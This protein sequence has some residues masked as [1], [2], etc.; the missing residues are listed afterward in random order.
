MPFGVRE[1]SNLTGQIQSILDGYPL[2]DAILREFLQN[3]DDAKA[4]KQIFVLDG[5]SHPKKYIADPILEECQGPALLAINDT[6]FHRDDWKALGTIHGSNKATDETKTGKY[7]LGFRACYHLT[8]NPHVLSG[9]QLR[10]FDPHED[11]QHPLDG[12]FFINTIEEAEKFVDHITAFQAAEVIPHKAYDGTA[13]RLPLRNDCQAK[14]SK[15]RSTAFS[16]DYIRSLFTNFVDRELAIVLLFLKHIRSVE[17]REIEANGTVKVIGRVEISGAEGSLRSD[18]SVGQRSFRCQTIF[19]GL[20]GKPQTRHWRIIHHLIGRSEACGILSPRLEYSPDE[21]KDTLQK[22]KLIP[23]V[24]LAMPLDSSG[25]DGPLFTL[26]PLPIRPG[27]PLCLHGTFSLTSDRQ[28]L[29]NNDDKASKQHREGLRVQWN[30]MIFDTLAPEAWA[31]LLQALIEEDHYPSL[32]KAWPPF[33]TGSS[34]YWSALLPNLLKIIIDTRIRVFPVSSHNRDETSPSYVSFQEAIFYPIKLEATL[35]ELLVR[36]GLFI[37]EP[38]IDLLPILEKQVGYTT[39][40]PKTAS[41][42]LRSHPSRVFK[43]SDEDKNTLLEYI[44]SDTSDPTRLKNLTGLP[45]LPLVNGNWVSITQ[46]RMLGAKTFVIPITLTEETLFSQFE[47]RMVALSALPISARPIFVN[48]TGN[49]LLSLR[50]PSAGDVLSYLKQAASAWRSIGVQTGDVSPQHIDWLVQ[51]WN[52]VDLPKDIN[53]KEFL[54]LQLIPTDANS[55]RKVSAGVLSLQNV[56]EGAA[57]ALLKLGVHILHPS[58][59]PSNSRIAKHCHTDIPFLIDLIDTHKVKDLGS[60]DWVAISN[61]LTRLLNNTSQPITLQPS[62][63]ETFRSL[64]IFPTWTGRTAESGVQLNSIVGNVHFISGTYEF[65]APVLRPP[66][67]FVLSS[68]NPTLSQLLHLNG[69][70]ETKAEP[71]ILQL[72]IDDWAEQ[73]P[74]SQQVYIDR[75]IARFSDLQASHRSK[76]TSF[77]FVS[78]GPKCLPPSE[79]IDPTSL[80]HKLYL[81]EG[82]T[83]TGTFGVGTERL[84]FLQVQGLLA[85]SLNP[86][87]V[88][89]RIDYIRRLGPTPESIRKAD[90]FL[91]LLD[92]SWDSSFSDIIKG[93][94]AISWLPCSSGSNSLSTPEQCRDAAFNSCLFDLCLDT[95]SFRLE[96]AGLRIALGWEAEIPTHIILSQLEKALEL[97][98][99]AQRLERVEIIIKELSG[100]FGR[101]SLSQKELEHL[102]ALIEDREWIPSHSEKLLDV[103]HA[104]LTTEFLGRAFQQVHPFLSAC[105]N[106]LKEMGCEDRPTLDA[107]LDEYSRY[108][109]TRLSSEDSEWIIRVLEE[110]S[111]YDLGAFTANLVL[112]GEGGVWWPYEQTYYDDLHNRAVSSHEAFIYPIHPSVS[113]TLAKKLKIPPLSALEL[114]RDEDEDEDEDEEG[115][116]EM[117]VDRIKNVLMD[118]D[119]KHAFNEF[120]ANAS[121]AGATD[122]SILLDERRNFSS[123]S[124]ISPDLEQFQQVPAVILYN[125]ASFTREDFEGIR[126]IGRG[127]KRDQSDAIGKYGLGALSVFHFTD[128]PMI[129][130]NKHVM[131]LDPSGKYLPPKKGNK[132]TVLFRKLSTFSSRYPDHLE[133]FRG[134]FN[135]PLTGPIHEVQG[136]LFRLPLP[137]GIPCSLPTNRSLVD[138]CGLLQGY[139]DLGR[140]GFF[141]TR[142]NR[143]GAGY[144]S[145]QS[146]ELKDEYWWRGHVLKREVAQ[147]ACH[148]V[149]DMELSLNLYGERATSEHW[150]ITTS[151]YPSSHAPDQF[152]PILYDLK[153][154]QSNDPITIQTAFPLFPYSEKFYLFSTLR[155]PQA[156]GLPFHLQAPFAIPS[157]RRHIHF[158]SRDATG[159]T[160]LPT[161]Y[162][163]WVLRELVPKHY[164]PTLETLRPMSP[165]FWTH[166]PCPEASDDLSHVV[167]ESFYNQLPTSSSIILQSLSN[168]WLAPGQARYCLE[169]SDSIQT[170]LRH[171]EGD[172]VVRPHKRIRPAFT[173][174][175]SVITPNLLA[176][177]LYSYREEIRNLFASGTLSPVDIDNLLAHLLRGGVDIS[178]LPLLVM[179]DENLCFRR[180]SEKIYYIPHPYNSLVK[181]ISSSRVLNGQIHATSMALLLENP[182]SGV[183][184]LS[185][186]DVCSLLQEK[187]QI[188]PAVTHSPEIT[189]WIQAFWAVFLY[190]PKRP[191]WD[192]LAD[193]PIVP[194]HQEHQY[195]SLRACRNGTVLPSHPFPDPDIHGVLSA[196]TISMV[197]LKVPISLQDFLHKET[198]SVVTLLKC[199]DDAMKTNPSICEVPR[200]DQLA[201]WIRENLTTT[202][203]RAVLGIIQHLPIWE[204]CLHG[205]IS[206]HPL[207]EILLLPRSIPH[208]HEIIQEYTRHLLSNQDQIARYSDKKCLTAANVLNLLTLPQTI[209]SHHLVPYAS[210]LKLL[211]IPSGNNAPR[212]QIPDGHRTMKQAQELY[213]V[214]VPLF[215]GVFKGP[216]EKTKFIHPAIRKQL[217]P[218]ISSHLQN[219]VNI[220]TVIACARELHGD[221]NDL[222]QDEARGRA[223][224]VYGAYTS[225]LPRLVMADHTTWARFNNLRFIPRENS[226]CRHA[227]YPVDAYFHHNQLPD[228]ISPSQIVSRQYERVAWTQRGLLPPTVGLGDLPT[229][230]PQFG[231]PCPSDVVNHLRFLALRIAPDH[232]WNRTLI[233]DLEATYKWL[234]ENQQEAREFLL[235]SEGVPLFLNV[236]D[237]QSDDWNWYSAQQLMLGVTWDSPAKGTYYVRNFLKQYEGVLRAAGVEKLHT[238]EYQ[239]NSP[240]DTR[241]SFQEVYNDMRLAGTVIDLHLVPT[242]S[243]DT[244]DA[245]RLRC[246]KSFLAASVPHIREAMANWSEA[247]TNSYS[248]TGTFTGAYAFLE[249]IYTGS[250][251][252]PKELTLKDEATRAELLN[253]LLGLFELADQWGMDD[254]KEEIGRTVVVTFELLDLDTYEA[255]M[256][257]AKRYRADAL[258]RA[259]ESFEQKNATAILRLAGGR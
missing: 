27:L 66:G 200:F 87:R 104:M 135:I 180:A 191:T 146:E 95:L 154:R 60:E 115:M 28:H 176:Q 198:F 243:D 90:A 124:I 234:N 31:K 188:S 160:T 141:F 153:I 53:L 232:P 130:S 222:S 98:E 248:F 58:I 178:D 242:K 159:G 179:A 86:N 181:W 229:V 250:I 108:T 59:S 15:I 214:N 164:L 48:Y 12:G 29:K 185:D 172:S 10:I 36:A 187:L 96:N 105:S 217:S 230:H 44:L 199:L 161:D 157:S 235:T 102:G 197:R 123:G 225:D 18:L 37:V 165:G 78:V 119:I 193:F 195:V 75:I 259:C 158:D 192:Q 228:V 72:A 112:P 211:R 226:R 186:E 210:F 184:E 109:P 143:L 70:I 128:L 39:L 136:T 170:I 142:M 8:D 167:S 149:T 82:L 14:R 67:T 118:Y 26:L 91:R 71:A 219:R 1:K 138:W 79:V 190:F 194:T 49:A 168:S 19:Q 148:T 171:L 132:R 205:R 139:Q 77:P 207:G 111:R 45:L 69:R 206:L 110:L 83:P 52:D 208:D 65:L 224:L 9:D 94:R 257:C 117:L 33:V 116:A 93:T 196:L 62:Q 189:Q 76:F 43:C 244:I 56:D 182:N 22:E 5:R 113:S 32:V 97:M 175:P 17:L 13:I 38:S 3:S 202:P 239:S 120:V 35:I 258:V 223:M 236:N 74:T 177:V 42:A 114:D 218:S 147:R 212:F 50:I 126:R 254:F 150:I 131:I 209:P 133:P 57:R 137:V 121:D 30:R 163:T 249:F 23:H 134:L 21:L 145:F 220:E 240:S 54:K 107:L 253:E 238:A 2:G 221:L 251:S 151:T 100:R 213:D 40:S 127:T 68:R 237:P 103:Q 227:S 46:S 47:T 7:G 64:K 85:S 61:Y 201:K 84:R 256:D 255:V 204:A 41:E 81:D 169:S 25:I 101:E 80:L 6:L 99:V 152:Q 140:N 183:R 11:F 34:V 106:F 24:G 88:A 73:S 129:I 63:S 122:F 166:W 241:V 51:F 173:N 247:G 203:D 174:Y 92:Q 20:D 245:Q 125:D 16:A 162:N 55:V 4:T 233:T 231:V 144:I 156:I 252:V 216:H 246:H 89:D 215:A 155:L